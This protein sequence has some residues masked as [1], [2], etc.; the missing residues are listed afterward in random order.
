MTPRGFLQILDWACFGKWANGNG[1]LAAIV[2]DSNIPIVGDHP[3]QKWLFLNL[4][5]FTFLVLLLAN[6]G[7][8]LFTKSQRKS[9]C[10][11]MDLFLKKNLLWF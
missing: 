2:Y 10:Y 6:I 5:T 11:L 4:M 9:L 3:F 1:A 8:S 7:V